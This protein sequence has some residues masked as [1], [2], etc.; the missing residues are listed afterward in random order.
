MPSVADF[1]QDKATY[2]DGEGDDAM[3]I[4][5]RPSAFDTDRTDDF[6]DRI[7]ENDVLAAVHLLTGLGDDDALILEWNVTGPLTGRRD[8]IG[9]D[10]EP[11]TDKRGRVMR[12]Q[13]EA[14]PAGKTIPLDPDVLRFMHPMILVGIYGRLQED[15]A[16]LVSTGF[17]GRK[18]TT[19]LPNGSR[20]RS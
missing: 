10:G 19:T 7:A 2:R 8:V 14:V 1:I 20:P 3:E 18:T 11:V 15:A 5:Y 17:L 4:V 9:E 6:H 12:E 16:R 13:Y